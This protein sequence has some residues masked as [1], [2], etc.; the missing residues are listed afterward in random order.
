MKKPI[1]LLLILCCLV[2]S[3]CLNISAAEELEPEDSRNI[4]DEVLELFTDKD[5]GMIVKAYVTPG[6]SVFGTYDTIEDIL[7]SFDSTD[8][9]YIQKNRGEFEIYVNYRDVDGYSRSDEPLYNYPV[10]LQELKSGEAIYTISENIMVEEVY[11][12][13]DSANDAGNAIYYRTD[14]GDYVFLDNVDVGK[15][16]LSAEIFW[17][18]LR[19]VREIHRRQNEGQI[20]IGGRD[21]D[22][23]DMSAYDFRSPNFDPDQPLP[24]IEIPESGPNA[25]ASDYLW[26][27]L[28]AVPLAAI[29]GIWAIKRRKPKDAMDRMI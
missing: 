1:T 3:L 6:L 8:V 13:Y 2:S 28:I 14:L 23:C 7:Q 4:P 16:L 24:E 18:Y 27:L 25:K 21:F 17:E 12:L 5:A 10:V 19:T 11:F 15:I 9:I 26:I 22:I 29:L 20:L